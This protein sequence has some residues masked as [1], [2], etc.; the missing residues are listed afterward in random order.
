M[1]CQWKSYSAGRSDILPTEAIFCQNKSCSANIRHIL[2]SCSAQIICSLNVSFVLLCRS[3]LLCRFN[4]PSLGVRPTSIVVSLGLATYARRYARR[5]RRPGVTK[6]VI[7]CAGGNIAGVSCR[8]RWQPP[9]TLALTTLV[10]QC[11]LSGC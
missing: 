11:E 10:A 8:R 3:A 7:F 5:R 2:Q 4:I 6:E 9:T 1:F